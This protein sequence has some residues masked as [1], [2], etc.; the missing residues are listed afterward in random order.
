M[1]YLTVNGKKLNYA[2]TKLGDSGGTS[3]EG[4][5]TTTTI[6]F[7]H[8]LGSTQNYFFPILPYLSE[9]RCILLDSYGAGRSRLNSGGEGEQEQ[10]HSIETIGK[11][12][13]GIMDA[14]DVERA[15]VVGYSMGG[16]VPT[17][18]A[19]KESG[20]V[21]AGVCIGPVHPSPAV[22]EVFKKRIPAVREGMLYLLSLTFE[23]LRLR[24]RLIRR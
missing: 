8:G 16:M 10:E 11:D 18:L 9:Y 20:R 1:P 4:K 23:V 24:L 12:V 22:A 14:L 5:S 19:A 3:S 2:D 13:I 21:L 15:V 7:V 6:V 17:W